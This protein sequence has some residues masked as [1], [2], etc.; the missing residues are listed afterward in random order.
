MNNEAI[1]PQVYA[2][3]HATRGLHLET[4]HRAWLNGEVALRLAVEGLTAYRH[5]VVDCLF[6]G[7]W[8]LFCSSIV[9][10]LALWARW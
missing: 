1:N 7:A 8:T 9:A 2:K 10:Y 5:G 4:E 3:L 6:W